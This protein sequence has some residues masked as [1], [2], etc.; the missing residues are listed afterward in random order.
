MSR[1]TFKSYAR[2]IVGRRAGRLRH[3][4]RRINVRMD[5]EILHG[6][7][8]SCRRL[9]TALWLFKKVFEPGDLARWRFAMHRLER[10]LGAAR[11]L[12]VEI[13]FFSRIGLTVGDAEAVRSAHLE[14]IRARRSAL[15]GR[16]RE[17]VGRFAK[18]GVLEEMAAVLA[19][20]PRNDWSAGSRRLASNAGKKIARRLDEL[21]RLSPYASRP[22]AVRQLHRMRIT[23][24]HLRYTLECYRPFLGRRVGRFTEAAHEVQNRLGTVHDLDTWLLALRRS[25]GANGR[26]ELIMLLKKER[27]VAFAVF[28]ACWNRFEHRGIWNRLTALVEERVHAGGHGR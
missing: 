12:D 20:L 13:A 16:V 15:D 27:S 22:G 18:G 24:K 21:M 5:A 14:R 26:H 6:I 3:W 11:D 10:V 25:A 28:S 23:A 4:I 2:I 17:G 9:R 19:G 1:E 7:R 8:I